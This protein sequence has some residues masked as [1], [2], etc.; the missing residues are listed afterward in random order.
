M[1][2]D[3]RSSASPS[4][5]RST[6]GALVRGLLLV[7]VAVL[8]G[9]VLLS[10]TDEPVPAADGVEEVTT[11][12]LDVG[13]RQRADDVAIG[14]PAG[15]GDATSTTI[16]PDGTTDSTAEGVATG[17]DDTG[18]DG[19][20]SDDTDQGGAAEGSGDTDQGGDADGSRNAEVS[21]DAD[22]DAEADD[23]SDEGSTGGSAPRRAGQVTVLV[24]NGSGVSGRAAELTE[25][26]GTAGYRT[27]APSNV[28][29]GDTVPASTVYYAEGFEAD[30]AAL[31]ATLSPPPQVTELPEP[32][33]VSDLRG[34]QILL[35]LGPDLE[36]D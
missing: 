9:V 16:E 3:Q 13:R 25:Q 5:G 24:A 14:D 4:P 35:V 26:V 31:A 19:T 33:P 7:A 29:G 15:D 21:G 1:S 32:S 34:A 30:A 22:R 10:A 11:G 6:G 20:G 8:L 18:S 28:N 2:S 12:D 27:A 36:P 23:S 17:Q